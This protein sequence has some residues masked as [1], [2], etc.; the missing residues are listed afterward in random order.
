MTYISAFQC[1]GGVVLCA[2]TQETVED[3]KQ[4]VEKLYTPENLSYPIA[5]GGA[6]VEE[7]I[8]AFAI[9]VFER[10]EK[11]KP[12]TAS[13]LR[14][15][16]KSAIEKVHSSDATVSAWP[17]G[18]RTTQCLVAAKPSKDEFCI[19]K[20]TGKRVSYRQKEPLIIG[21]ATVSNKALM[22][23]MYRNQLPMQQ[24][25]MLA[26]YLLS[27]SKL[28]DAHVGGEPRIV[29]VAENG[30]W[31]D[32]SDYIK[33]TEQY[34]AD[35]LRLIDGLFLN[36]VD[37]TIAPS[38]YPK[39]LAEFSEAASRLRQEF[40][41]YSAVRGLQRTFHDPTY[42]G[43]PYNKLFL[44]ALLTISV[45]P[46]GQQTLAE[47]REETP[48]EKEHRKQTFQLADEKLNRNREANLR[49][50]RLVEGR[51]PVYLGHEVLELSPA[52]SA[53]VAGQTK[54]CSS[55]EIGDTGQQS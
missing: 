17:K 41:Q 8:E 50:A 46:N 14:E 36:S 18:Y 30:A 21:Y 6:G 34:I 37:V 4:Y 24:A 43:D 1:Q 5:I 15:L 53:E 23:R 52:K 13:D 11:D 32:D 19:F 27:Q 3:E 47:I 31:I 38:D 10:V 9:E 35:F 26:I 2:D 39:K 7:P 20:V 48:E 29:I 54:V 42:R 22:K 16:L 51:L 12:Q 45:S 49:F 55:A 25:V 40:V 28:K 33:R 44:G